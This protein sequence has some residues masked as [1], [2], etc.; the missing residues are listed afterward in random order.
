MSKWYQTATWVLFVV[1][2]D[3]ALASG[4][5]VAAC[6]AV[7]RLL[8]DGG[9]T[10]QCTISNSPDHELCI[11]LGTHHTLLRDTVVV[12]KLPLTPA[13]EAPE[14]QILGIHTHS[15]AWFG[16]RTALAGECRHETVE[17]G[18]WSLTAQL[19]QTVSFYDNREH[20]AELH[21]NY[22][23]NSGSYSIKV[24]DYFGGDKK[25]SREIWELTR[26]RR[27]TQET[28]SLE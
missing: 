20:F 23:L 28:R 12:S 25:T 7:S 16:C 10:Y 5:H 24:V 9:T 22:L 15:P 13:G 11:Q 4:E 2:A 21:L 26:C 14:P 18:W 8:Q 6:P 17:L 19:F 27:L 1:T 3:L